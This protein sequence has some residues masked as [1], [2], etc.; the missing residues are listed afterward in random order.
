VPSLPGVIQGLRDPLGAVLQLLSGVLSHFVATARADLNTE[1]TRYLF[2][3]VDPSVPGARP[4]TSNPTIAQL[5]GSLALAADVLVGAVIV[6]ASLRGMFE[7]NNLRARYGLKVALPRLL[8]A[9]CLVHGSMFF[10]QMGIDLNNAIGRTALSTGGALTPDALPW[11]GSLDPAAVQAIQ[12]SQDLFHAIFSLALVVALVIL[13]LSYVVRTAL[14][15]I[16]IVLAPLA[17]IFT[18]LP[19]T[20]GYARMWLRLFLVT[21]FMQALQL[22]ILRVATAAA[23][24]SGSGI[25]ESLYA[26]ATLWIMLKVPATLHSASHFET[27]AHSLGRHMERSMHR[28]LTPAHHA[29]ARPRAST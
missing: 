6:F 11:S 22:I 5:N 20:R 13:V 21:V 9:I 26:L 18:V 14:L 17:A 4:L 27:K 2:T 7:H 12:A 25:A 8:V 19:D 1:L 16:L 15:E 10:M 24:S 23:F 28:A 3:T 29:V